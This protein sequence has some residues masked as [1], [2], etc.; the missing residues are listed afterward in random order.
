MD[1]KLERNGAYELIAKVSYKF[2]DLFQA[3]DPY[4]ECD[5]PKGI[6]NGG[7]EQVITFKFKPPKVD[8]LL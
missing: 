7:Q 5:M 1:I 8:K 4:F 6:L 3:A 2:T